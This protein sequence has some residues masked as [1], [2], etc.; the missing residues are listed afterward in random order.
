MANAEYIVPLVK[1]F[2]GAVF[3]DAGNAWASSG[4]FNLSDLVSG[5]GVGIRIMSPV[6]PLRLDYA[7]GIDIKETHIHF[8]IGWPF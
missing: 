8:T 4:D 6:G 1:D 7:Y 5:V 3:F 2:K